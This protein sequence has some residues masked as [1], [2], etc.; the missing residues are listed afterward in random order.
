MLVEAIAG[1]FAPEEFKDVYREGVERLIASKLER[2][3][4]AASAPAQRPAAA[5]VVN[6]M[7]ALKKS[8][9]LAKKPARPEA[10]V[11]RRK[12]ERAIEA[13]SSEAKSKAQR[14]KA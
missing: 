1:P 14:R 8:L 4:V 7:D 13:K 12:P 9:E 5:P 6:I 3:E 10:E 11:P 2:N